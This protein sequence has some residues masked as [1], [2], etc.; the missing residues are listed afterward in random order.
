MKVTQVLEEEVHLM[1]R[2]A[3]QKTKELIIDALA[4]GNDAGCN[5]NSN[6]KYT[7]EKP[8]EVLVRVRVEHMGFSTLN[9]QRFGAKFV[10][11]IAN[12][13]DILLFHR[14]KDMKLSSTATK[15]SILPIPPDELE[16]TNMEDLVK[17]Q[18]EAPDKQL[19]LLEEH[20][21]SEAMENYV[22]K[23]LVGAIPDKAHS[24]LK[25]KQMKLIKSSG[26]H[27]LETN[28]TNKVD[29][30]SQQ[31]KHDESYH[32]DLEDSRRESIM[33]VD[34]SMEHGSKK[35]KVIETTINE[36]EEEE[37]VEENDYRDVP[38]RRTSSNNKPLAAA[39]AKKST[40]TTRTTS[41]A[42]TKHKTS[43]RNVVDIMDD[44]DD[45]DISPPTKKRLPQR[46][47]NNNKKM[48]YSDDRSIEAEDNID[49][50]SD[51]DVV[52][53]SK[54]NKKPAAAKVT[55]TTSRTTTRQKNTPPSQRK[56]STT[57]TATKRAPVK[58]T[59]TKLDDSDEDDGVDNN[60]DDLDDDWGTAVN[61]NR[62]FR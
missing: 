53:V 14:K 21:L 62:R 10:S 20:E 18:L 52:V 45:D 26:S 46:R 36:S 2:N 37:E 27:Q 41:A 57:G 23:S 58:K 15:K 22:E 61:E 47:T 50:D 11:E 8:D 9:N 56:T 25:K 31:H 49:E 35:R 3:R 34:D 39:V 19:K 6:I 55:S 24:L 12:P 42:A 32:N 4:A 7:I 33:D 43:S 48:N 44:E 30:K 38:S 28:E 54:N 16:K 1:I 59:T 40:T 60:N 17:E 29:S 51:D 5:K 13:G